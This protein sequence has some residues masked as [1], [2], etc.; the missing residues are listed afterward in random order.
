[1]PVNVSSG[2]QVRQDFKSNSEIYYGMNNLMAVAL[3]KS[4]EDEV[5]PG[6]H[7]IGQVLKGECALLFTN[8]DPAAVRK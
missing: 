1:M 2:F 4:D 7:R 8:E 6:L 5:E 3:G